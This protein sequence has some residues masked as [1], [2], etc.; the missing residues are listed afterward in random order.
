MLKVAFAAKTSLTTMD[1]AEGARRSVNAL[2]LQS[3]VA[4]EE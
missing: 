2:V 1:C 3:S 4:G